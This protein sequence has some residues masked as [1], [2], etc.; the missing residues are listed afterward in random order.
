MHKD[1]AKYYSGV[2]GALMKLKSPATKL[3][4]QQLVQVYNKEKQS[5]VYITGPLCEG[6]PPWSAES[7]AQV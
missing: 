2:I 1:T 6:I 4:V 7:A 3:C 5:K